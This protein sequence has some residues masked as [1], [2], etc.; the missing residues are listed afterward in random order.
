MYAKDRRNSK[1]KK[2]R[3]L[4]FGKAQTLICTLTKLDH[5]F[6]ACDWIY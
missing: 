5:V 1:G 2:Y 4:S 3:E 6:I